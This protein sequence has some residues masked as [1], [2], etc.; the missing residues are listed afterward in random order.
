MTAKQFIIVFIVC[1]LILILLGVVRPARAADPPA[2][3]FPPQQNSDQFMY[4]GVSLDRYNAHSQALRETGTWTWR[5]DKNPACLGDVRRYVDLAIADLSNT[6]GI[7]FIETPLSNHL[8]YQNCGPSLAARCGATNINCLGRGYPYDVTIDL[9][10]DLAGYF[11][12]SS[13]SIVEHELLHAMA[14]YNEQYKLDGSFSPSSD[15]TV[16][17]TGPLSRHYQQQADRERWWRTMGSPE[18]KQLGYG[19]NGAW[20]IWACGFDANATRLS[21][22]VDEGSG[23]KWSGVIVPLKPDRNGCQGIGVPEGLRIVVG[24]T[25][26]LKAENA[27]SWKVS[28]NEACVKGS[29]GC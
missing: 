17:N 5:F 21:V 29:V 22:L 23:V 13:V 3:L 20:Y 27:A 1:L 7:T 18:L 10:S 15:I 16:M 4:N 8:I 19:F 9:S 2:A 28:R 6:Y 11:E 25:Y 26:Y 24:S 14:T 12:V